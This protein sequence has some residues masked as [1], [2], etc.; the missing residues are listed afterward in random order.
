MA[1]RIETYTHSDKS[2]PNKGGAIVAVRSQTDFAAR[3]DEFIA[4]AQKVA[5][6]SFAAQATN[7]EDVTAAFPDLEDERVALTKAIKEK[8]EIDQIVILTI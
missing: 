6:M 7:W 2:V 3:T 5:K 8:V 4:F 1:G